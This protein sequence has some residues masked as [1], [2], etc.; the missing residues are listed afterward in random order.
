MA[1]QFGIT[2][3][4][5][6]TKQQNTIIQEINAIIQT[7]WGPN[8]NL[9]PQSN[10]GQFAGIFSE[11]EALIWQLLEAV[12]D[13]QYPGGAEGTSVD[14]I[15][16][17]NNLRRLPATG[18]ITNSDP[19]VQSAAN[20]DEVTLYGL[21]L[22]GIPGT[23]IPQ[24]STVQTQ[25]SPTLSFLTQA[26]YTIGSLVNAVQVLF[27]S[28]APN[29][30]TFQLSF[31][32]PAGETCTTESLPFNALAAQTQFTIGTTPV[33]SSH[34][35]ITLQ[36]AGASLTTANISTNAAYPTAAA[37]QTAIQALSGYSGA[38]VVR[39]GSG[40]FTY[41]ITWNSICN[42][43]LTIA[44]DT[45]GSTI[46]TIDS[47]QAA[48]NNLEDSAND[49]YPFTDL[50]VTGALSSGNVSF[51]F[52]GGSIVGSNPSC[53]SQQQAIFSVT[54]NTLFASSTATNLQVT[55]T[56]IGAGVWGTGAALSPT[57]GLGTA[58]GTVAGVALCTVTGPNF[59]ADGA[60]S[61]I[62]S[63][64][65]GWQGV[66]NQLPCITGTNLESDTAALT[67]RATLL[68][69]NANTPL[70]AIID[71]VTTL[72]EPV[73]GSVIGFQNTTQ[74]ALQILTFG[75]VPVSGSFNLIVGTGSTA[76]ISTFTAG[77][78][79]TA[80]RAIPGYPN[81]NVT[82]GQTGSNPPIFTIDFNGSFGGQPQNLLAIFS[83]STGSSITPSFGRPGSSVEIVV[84]NQGSITNTE[85]A[86][87]ILAN[88][89]GGIKAYGNVNTTVF[90]KYNNAYVIGF[91]V[92]TEINFYVVISLVTDFYN[93]PGN[94][95][96]GVNPIASFSP[97]SIS[98]ILQDILDIGNSFGIGAV[99]TA[100]QVIGF[101]S[102]GLIGAF[103]SVP[104]II[105]YTL[106]FG[107]APN[108]VT[109]SNI[110]LLQ[111][112]EAIFTALNTSISWS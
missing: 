6:V 88:V 70:A 31:Y 19:D 30:G 20:V 57:Q 14:N 41:T 89:A 48:V 73:N 111:E 82:G 94:S 87:T 103:N 91:S 39:T 79:Q 63:A 102:N 40:P 60:L 95:G 32:D 100:G 77:A 52:G 10:F 43:L 71:A 78:I 61:L 69:S 58:Y 51:T 98:E 92:P 46:S 7:I 96:S 93:I 65:T 83:N 53:A 9:A 110:T 56:I 74:S 29:S 105:S 55:Q 5:F 26:T 13:S 1:N 18:T 67:R 86:Q 8:V 2:A 27:L 28:N 75:S 36:K 12:Y 81:V 68:A 37:V 11:R 4:G 47:I 16:A 90:D 106:F 35:G 108:P 104:G 76:A 3:T 49:Y 44:N 80:I 17:L 33:A 24:N 99:A 59:V 21:L 97:G 64:A 62:G 54:S 34:F 72:V 101:G 23:P 109:N 112:Q 15:L 84:G 66:I 107:T 85:I 25:G 42:P 45:T 38:T 22:W 50:V